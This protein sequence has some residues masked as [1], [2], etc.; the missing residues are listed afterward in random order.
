MVSIV[1]LRNSFVNAK[2]N[3][4]AIYELKFVKKI[5]LP[6]ALTLRKLFLDLSIDRIIPSFPT[7]S[8]ALKPNY[9]FPLIINEAFGLARGHLTIRGLLP[10]RA[11]LRPLACEYTA[12]IKGTTTLTTKPNPLLQN[13]RFNDQGRA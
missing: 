2:T 10:R 7:I 12:S 8:L 13:R 11:I 6:L 9:W 4:N 3:V 5:A 1:R